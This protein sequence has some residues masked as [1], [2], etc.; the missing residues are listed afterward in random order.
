M[1]IKQKI[2]QII[3]SDWLS[4]IGVIISIGL[5]ALEFLLTPWDDIENLLSKIEL[6]TSLIL[7][8]VLC[9]ISVVGSLL[10]GIISRII[11]RRR[12]EKQIDRLH[13]TLLYIRHLKKFEKIEDKSKRILDELVQ[14]EE[15]T[16]Q[17]YTN[18]Q[19][20]TDIV[21]NSSV[22]GVELSNKNCVI[23]EAK[24]AVDRLGDIS[25]DSKIE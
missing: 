2:D 22:F 18:L 7:L 10:V 11:I 14:T 13:T 17:Q 1:K 24:S 12:L 19:N 6:S 5:I 4:M 25:I 20:L 3:F 16:K 21:I 8:I 9:N 15:I 23:D